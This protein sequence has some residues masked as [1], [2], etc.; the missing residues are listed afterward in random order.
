MDGSKLI[1]NNYKC[2]IFNL[3]NS[4]SE[5][6]MDMINIIEDELGTRAKINYKKLQQGDIVESHSDIN[7]SIKKLD[8][9]PLIPIKKGIPFFVNWYKN[10]Y[11]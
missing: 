3:G 9:K 7:K 2:E 8:Y 11:C 1:K 5:K 4:K 10:Y 6:L